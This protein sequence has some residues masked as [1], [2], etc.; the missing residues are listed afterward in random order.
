MS[1]YWTRD[2]LTHNVTNRTLAASQTNQVISELAGISAGDSLFLLWQIKLSALVLTNAISFK[3][4]HTLG[5]GV[6]YDVG[7]QANVAAVQKTCTDSD[8]DA[9]ANT[10]TITSHGFL[11]GDRVLLS[12][13]GTLP[14]D[15]TA[16]EV[17]IIKVDANTVKIAASLADAIAGT[18]I[19]I[20]TTGSGTFL[21]GQADYV[22]RLLA[23]D[24]S[25]VA[26]LPLGG[27]VRLVV[28]S[29]ASDTAT[30]SGVRMSH[31]A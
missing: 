11:T 31:R 24:S 23:T 19:D 1:G 16:G 8:V 22:G 5:D 15:A 7:S 21:F 3:L 4:Q 20:S 2:I 9:T 17:W 12:T 30:I 6:W 10:F 18:A 13:A 14:A 27:A 26:Q 28:T 25:D 29:G